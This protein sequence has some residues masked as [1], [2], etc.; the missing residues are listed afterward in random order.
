[1]NAVMLSR[2]ALSS[3]SDH[4]ASSV[5]SQD[6]MWAVVVYKQSSNIFSMGI[7]LARTNM[8]A[9]LPLVLL[10]AVVAASSTGKFICLAKTC[11]DWNFL[12][13]ICTTCSATAERMYSKN[14]R[15]PAARSVPTPAGLR[16]LY[17]D[18]IGAHSV[19]GRSPTIEGKPVQWGQE[20]SR[21]CSQLSVECLLSHK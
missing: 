7:N 3:G 16:L 12:Y 21:A 10:V 6:W 19:P 4:R 2:I 8:S 9:A 15:Q 1:M 11:P 18:S 17:A 14:S 13:T 20:H 5:L